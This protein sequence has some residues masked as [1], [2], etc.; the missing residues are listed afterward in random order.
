MGNSCNENGENRNH[1][2][3][4]RMDSIKNKTSLET[5]VEEDLRRMKITG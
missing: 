3:N 1:Q 5:Q 4:N 2:K